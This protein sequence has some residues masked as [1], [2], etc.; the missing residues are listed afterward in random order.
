MAHA[1][2]WGFFF[3]LS[4]MSKLLWQNA[5][6]SAFATDL[7][8]AIA[9]SHFILPY[10]NSPPHH[11]NFFK[12][13]QISFT[14]CE[15][16]SCSCWDFINRGQRHYKVRIHSLRKK[17]YTELLF[18]RLQKNMERNGSQ[19][20]CHENCCV[21]HLYWSLWFKKR[22]VYHMTFILNDRKR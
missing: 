7:I 18:K 21:L 13:A 20:L 6:V 12:K 10:C 3:F 1:L 15:K 8:K 22:L 2:K 4:H 17:K 11:V 19:P 16:E 9:Y 5:G 14:Q